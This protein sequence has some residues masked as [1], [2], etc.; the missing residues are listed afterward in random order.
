[1]GN[2]LDAFDLQRLPPSEDDEFE[3]KSSRISENDLKR[4][5]ANAASAFANSGGGFFIGGVDG[6]GNADNGLHA[7]IGRQ[8]IATGLIKSYTASH[9]RQ[10]TRS[11]LL[12]PLR[13]AEQL[14]PAMSC[15]Y[16]RS[17]KARQYRT[18]QA[19]PDSIFVQVH[20][21]SRQGI[22]SSKPSGR[23]DTFENQGSGM[24]FD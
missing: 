11:N 12:M 13:G 21:L 24:C 8:P 14:F 9:R 22:L 19:I 20:I 3:F 18:C 4:E 10:R 2:S 7:T 15:W 5:I 1:M 6:H 17:T 23:N 16:W